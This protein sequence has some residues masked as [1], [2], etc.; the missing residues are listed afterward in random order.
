MVSLPRTFISIDVNDEVL[1]SLKPIQDDLRDTG[2]DLKLVRPQNIHMTLRFLGD[3][4]KSRLEVIEEAIEGI[5]DF[6]PFEINLEGLGVFPEP[7]YIRVVW[8]GVSKG[9]DE[10]CEVK[11]SLESNLSSHGFSEDDKD[12]TPHFTIARVKSG[13]AKD[14]LNSIVE[15]TSDEFFGSVFVDSVE[16]RKS[17]LT[18][19]GPVYSTISKFEF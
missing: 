2:A 11:E 18:S 12:F 10:L 4:S 7:S 1:N 14:K 15:E 5:T 19:E 9:S 17:E 8:A 6:E 16:L 3:V 13:K